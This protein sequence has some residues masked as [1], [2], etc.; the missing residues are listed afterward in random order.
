MDLQPLTGLAP[1]VGAE[2]LAAAL[3]AVLAQG[4]RDRGFRGVRLNPLGLFLRT[5]TRRMLSAFPSA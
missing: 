5:S 3:G 1:Q 2:N 4:E